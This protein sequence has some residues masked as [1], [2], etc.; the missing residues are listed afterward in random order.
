MYLKSEL[1]LIVLSA[2]DAVLNSAFIFVNE[3]IRFS[4]ITNKQTS[5]PVLEVVRK[6]MQTIGKG[7]FYPCAWWTINKMCLWWMVVKRS[8]GT[9]YRPLY[10]HRNVLFRERLPSKAK[11]F[12]PFL[13]YI[14]FP[15]SYLTRLHSS[16]SSPDSSP[17]YSQGIHGI[18]LVLGWLEFDSL[19]V[20]P[21]SNNSGSGMFRMFM[22]S[23]SWM[24]L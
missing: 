12:F 6:S 5:L 7:Q 24:L 21:C 11:G 13:S 15:F 19:A 16:D 18:N 17:A 4:P 2:R 9:N 8:G 20:E 22:G 14:V 10:L 3:P 1:C 23:L